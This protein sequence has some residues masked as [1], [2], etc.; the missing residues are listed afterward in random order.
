MYKRSV[1][2]WMK[3]LDFI[4]WDVIG[5]QLAYVFAYF[6]R[7]NAGSPYADPEYLNMAVILTAVDVLVAVLFDTMHN[8]LQRERWMELVSMIKHAIF[9]FALL[10]V[11]LF[12]VKMGSTYSRITM[13]LTF[14][15]HIVF[16]YGLRQ[17]WKKV[18][19]K[20][21]VRLTKRSLLLVTDTD[22]VQEVLNNLQ[23]VVQPAGPVTAIVLAD[24]EAGGEINGIPVVTSLEEA[25]EY[26]CREW[27]D[28]VLLASEKDAEAMDLL[29][30]QCQEMGVAVHRILSRKLPVGQKQFVEKMGNY[31]VLTS[32]INY[33]NPVHLLLKRSM[34]I[35]GALAGCLFTGIIVAIIGPMIYK[36][37]PG[38]I[39]FTQERVGRNGR[40]FKMLK[41]RSMYMDAEERKK[42]LMSQ[43]RVS[44]G[45]M[46]KLDFD[47]RIIGNKILPDGTKK[48]G[49][50]EF[51]RKTSLDEFPQFINVLKGD[52]SLV[53]TRPPTMDEWEKY[54]LHHRA[55]LAMKPGI[56]G[57]WQVSGRSN[58]TDF[59][60]VVK[61]DT[62]YITSWSLGLDLR[63]LFKTV[64]AVFQKDGA[65]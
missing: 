32:S 21:G 47:P 14:G 13:Y 22:K 38:P 48:T 2:G 41:I 8:I 15:F 11:Y 33:A 7:Y 65:M 10:A 12:S 25:A 51:I 55:R 34:D 17:M 40:R 29:A 64:M 20:K 36:A 26:I 3:H 39:F 45:M 43:N 56:T 9:V 24:G 18:V 6:I 60:E 58:I 16:G 50:G 61:L 28:E 23:T 19:I 53:G 35:A 37:S 27:V 5:L 1:Q 52:M 30:F 44:D 4:L 62:Q 59:E 49:I 31:T 57:M 42:D 54:K 63:I 46:F